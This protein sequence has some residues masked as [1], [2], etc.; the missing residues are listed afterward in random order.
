MDWR[1]E[2]RNCSDQ[3]HQRPPMVQKKANGGRSIAGQQ[4]HGRAMTR[5]TRAHEREREA[6]CWSEGERVTTG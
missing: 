1:D 3:E 4:G 2:R 6:E 5:A